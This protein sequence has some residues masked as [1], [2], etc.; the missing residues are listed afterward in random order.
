M[1]PVDRGSEELPGRGHWIRGFRFMFL[2]APLLGLAPWQGHLVDSAGVGA[3]SW[4]RA[5]LSPLDCCMCL[6]AR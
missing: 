5:A 1:I 3:V 4:A 2:V 6:L